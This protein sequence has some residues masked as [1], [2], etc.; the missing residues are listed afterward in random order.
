M[1]L[2]RAIVTK[3]VFSGQIEKVLSRNVE[4]HHFAD[5]ECRDMYDY[6]V[7]HTR[8]YKSAPSLEAAKYDKPNFEWFQVQDT[9]DYLLDRFAVVV[10]H[11]LADDMLVELAKACDDPGRVENIEQEFVEVSRKLVTAVPSQ[12][13]ERFSEVE[14]RIKVYEKLKAEGKPI[15]IPYGLP[16]LDRL[17]GGLLKHELVTVLGFTNVGKS[18]LLRALGFNF[19]MGGFTPLYLS[20]E[21]EADV[22]LNILDSM[23]ARLDYTKMKQLQL[24]EDHMG[25]WRAFA[26]RMK[27]AKCDIPVLDSATRITPDYVFA[28][29]LRHKPDVVILDY[30][31]LMRSAS[32]SR[33]INRYQQI[34][35]IVE[36]LKINARMLKIPIIM[37]A[38]TGRAGARDGAE[39]E[40]VADAI[41]IIHHSDTVIGLFQD[42]DMERE[43]EMEVRLN[44]N[45]L[46][47]RGKFRMLWDFDRMIFR[48]KTMTDLFQRNGGSLNMDRV[49][50]GVDTHV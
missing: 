45:R 14:K 10:K 26:E 43:G 36:D 24:S 50:Q 49:D 4:L 12:E 8:K 47:P 20:L 13:I 16:T 15:G 48:E 41:S 23:A 37:A 42:A 7:R 25:N 44:K 5:D 35:E 27:N 30:V 40:N 34:S 29:T 18:T 28:E 21:M 38:Q 6:I 32:M 3:I 39:L 9:L 11:R 33:G 22:I 2:E 17:T 46:G 19:W 31:G 1:D